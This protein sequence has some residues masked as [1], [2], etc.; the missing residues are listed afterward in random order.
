MVWGVA[1]L[2]IATAALFLTP[3]VTAAGST[4]Q[5]LLMPG[6]VTSVMY[7]QI[8]LAAVQGA[9]YPVGAVLIGSSIILRWFARNLKRI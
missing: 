1:C 9:L 7:T 3:L 5:P 4:A 2:I 8:V 6:D